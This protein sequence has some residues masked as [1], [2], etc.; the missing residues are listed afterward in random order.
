[1]VFFKKR[2][3]MVDKPKD[4]KKEQGG[5]EAQIYQAIKAVCGKEFYDEN[6]KLPKFLE[7]IKAR[8]GDINKK[9]AL[10]GHEEIDEIPQ[11]VLDQIDDDWSVHHI[12][13][14]A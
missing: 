5:R 9:L 11:K 13:P 4:Q 14:G 2:G 3:A 7:T 10:E 6:N 1:M 12:G 8:I